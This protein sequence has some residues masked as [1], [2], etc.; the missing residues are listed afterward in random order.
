[1]EEL[2]TVNTQLRAKMEEL[3]KAS[4]DLR[5][6]LASTNI[7]VI[8]LDSQFRIRRYTPAARTLVELI[9][10]DVGRPLSDMAK[11]FVDP[12]LLADSQL[13]LERLVPAEREV[14]GNDGCWYTRRVL[15]YRTADDRIEGV[16]VT[17]VDIS[18]R[19]R[20]EDFAAR[21][22]RR[23]GHPLALRGNSL[24]A[25][26]NLM[27]SAKD[28]RG[29]FR[30]ILDA[31][32]DLHATDLADVRLYDRASG[33]LQV[34]VQRGFSE[35]TAAGWQALNF[36]DSSAP[37]VCALRDHRSI[38][39]VDTDRDLAPASASFLEQC[40][41]S[42]VR[43]LQCFPLVAR[44]GEIFGTLTVFFREPRQPDD[45][46]TRITELLARQGADIIERMRIEEERAR[47][48]RSEQLARRA[49]DD[50]ALMKDEFLAMLSHELRTPLSAILLWGRMIRSATLG[51]EELNQGID[52]I[53]S[54]AETQAR[55]ID[56]L[57]DSSR[58]A[59]GKLQL[60]LGETDL[61]ELVRSVI[62]QNEPAARAKD[63]RVESQLNPAAGV[64]IADGTRIRQV[65][66]NLLINA[67]KFTPDGGRICVFLDRVDDEAQI[68]ISDTGAGISAEF[69][70]NVFDRF[71][72][73]EASLTRK[74]GGLGLGLTISKQ[75]VEMHG[76]TIRAES[77]G[78]G[79]GSTFTVTLPLRALNRRNLGRGPAQNPAWTEA[80]LNGQKILLVE[81][82][83][84]TQAALAALL[85]QAGAR[86]TTA[87]TGREA[88][89]AYVDSAPQILLGD[90][91]LPDFDGYAL[92]DRIRAIEREQRLP[93]VH[94]V[95]LSAYAR[96]KDR[97]KSTQAG[98][99]THL[100]KPV[101]ADELIGALVGL[102]TGDNDES[103]AR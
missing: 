97:V 44:N 88:L 11:K 40:Q 37:P 47:V 52:A 80:A 29:V 43:A 9:G 38:A 8:F 71:R 83:P 84:E 94:A 75:L 27:I 49:L 99:S 45:R 102:L 91:G 66:W 23:R 57:L 20:A 55:L 70:P 87:A 86:V 1:N 90:L 34:T 13:V 19:K 79:Q 92:L 26:S 22:R 4:G 89:T 58:T 18:D 15:P 93:K 32:L 67:V 95:A 21:A 25:V 36:A 31:A 14:R 51:P 39:V 50:A 85:R 7:A 100:A 65:V 33:T 17:F 28:M 60:E 69:L 56:D 3:Q 5:S 82:D 63:L 78:L 62:E 59:A 30:E 16:V 54:S 41:A 68:R 35:A 98:Y 46:S 10:S 2:S 73:Y 77:A 6:L 103:E 96:E 74:Y 42:G 76:G 64:V 24:H 81:D 53:L 12:D 101:D 61:V 48:L 72:Q